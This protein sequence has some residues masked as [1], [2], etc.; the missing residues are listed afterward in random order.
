MAISPKSFTGFTPAATDFLRD[1]A[2]N[3]ERAWFTEHKPLYERDVVAPFRLLLT[4]LIPALAIRDLP[5]TCDPAKSLF[6]IHR[7]VRFS[8]DKRPYKT[9]AGAVLTRDGAK[10]SSGLLYI[11]LAPGGS[12]MASGF[13]T[14][15]REPLGALREAIYTEPERF[16]VV[17]SAL[18]EAG[19]ALDEAETLVRMPRGF[20]DAAGGPSAAALRLKSFVVYR[21]IAPARL[22]SPKLIDD[23]VAF[24]E[25]ALPLLRFGWSALS[26]LDPTALTRQK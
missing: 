11:H 2:D 13:H 7:D 16:A 4:A 17:Q 21:P 22:A 26:V 19:L 5:L 24:T 18:Q 15:D 6:R 10:G 23:I 8:N 25:Q 20:E 1:L 12:F 9:H 14:P 3:N